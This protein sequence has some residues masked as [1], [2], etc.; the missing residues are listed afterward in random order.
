M[1]RFDVGVWMFVASL[2]LIGLR[3]PVAV[4]MLLAGGAGYAAINGLEPLLNTL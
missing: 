3:M 2:V 4:A 1:S